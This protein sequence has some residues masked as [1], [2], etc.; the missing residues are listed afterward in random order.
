[1]NPTL[2]RHS[3]GVLALV[4]S[5]AAIAHTRDRHVADPDHPRHTMLAVPVAAGPGEPGHG[6][7]YFA[8]ADGRR[9]VVIS[10][11]GAYFLSRGDG[12]R[13]VTGRPDDPN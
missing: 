9:A 11:D 10:P 3:L 6:W 12:L 8:A 5:A 1:M 2:L 4:A 13:R 7:R